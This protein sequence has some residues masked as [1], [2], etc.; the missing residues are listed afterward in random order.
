MNHLT[1]KDVFNSLTHL[2][3]IGG[4]CVSDVPRR[5]P[6]WILVVRALGE[7]R[8]GSVMKYFKMRVGDISVDSIVVGNIHI[9]IRINTTLKC[10]Y[11][12]VYRYKY[13]YI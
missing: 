7:G 3:F 1:T 9:D 11:E 6:T 2:F 10:T 5:S 13:T 12:D 4:L 8:D